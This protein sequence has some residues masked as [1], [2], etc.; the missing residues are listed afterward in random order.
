MGK[1]TKGKLKIILGYAA[2]TGKTFTMLEEAHQL[3]EKGVDVV[4]GYIEPHNRKDTIKM[5]E[6]LEKIEPITVEY[7]GVRFRE[8]DL[9]KALARNPEVILVDEL[10]HSNVNGCRHRK[11]YQ[12]I[13]ELLR[14]GINVYTTVNIQHIESLK[15]I[16][17]AI[18][19]AEVK[20]RV[21]D[22]VFNEAE[23]VEV[24]DI[25]PDELIMRMKDGCIYEKVQAERA[26]EHFFRKEKLVALREIAL[27][28]AA[29]KVNQRAEEERW[30][31]GERDYYTGEHILVCVSPSPA[32]AKTIRA[33]RRLADAFHGEFTAMCVETSELEESEESIKIS[34]HKN[35]ELAASLGAKI[36]SVFGEDI[37]YQV[38][39]YAR[40]GN[41][42]KIVIGRTLNGEFQSKARE[43]LLERINSYAPNVDIF[44][45]PDLDAGKY[46]AQYKTIQKRKMKKDETDSA[47]NIVLNTAKITAVIAIVTVIGKIIEYLKITES[48]IAMLYI[49]GVVITA[50]MV[51]KKSYAFYSSALSVLAFN[52]FFTK[53]YY[54][55]SADKEHIVTFIIMFA[56][57]FFVASL[58]NKIRLENREN[59]KRAYRMELLLENSKLL[60]RC[61]SKSEVWDLIAERIQ[62]LI[63]LPIIIY[64]ADNGGKRLKG[65]RIYP[66]ALM[67]KEEMDK[68]LTHDEEAVASWVFL[69]GETA[70][71]CTATLPQAQAVYIP[72][73]TAQKIEG[74]LGVVLEE[75]RPINHFE[76]SIM[77]AMINETAVKLQ[78][79]FLK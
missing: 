57:A 24:V 55:L 66:K 73:Q 43:R 29:D 3:K 72:V 68:Y 67:K 42:S 21:P 44:I 48:N 61:S 16:V 37:A 35:M 34:L 77:M 10:A 56:V 12:D 20:E 17:G 54:S 22:S 4:A 78:D 7:K 5:A 38:A 71:A 62:K 64:T 25:E 60:R 32:C 69:N 27:R 41:I 49:L 76:F 14:A 58:T 46:A 28:K 11:R 70:G 9:D 39:E 63:D 52:F 26:L 40:A 2:G 13:E 36:I 23:Q 30:Q 50:Y 45:I 19:K 18:T 8:F 31:S 1:T 53:P 65:K 74:I 33:A 6:G 47:K 79:V 59:A 75:R 51:N 15:D